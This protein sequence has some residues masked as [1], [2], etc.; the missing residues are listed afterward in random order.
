MMLSVLL[1]NI[2]QDYR[3]PEPSFLSIQ[4]SWAFETWTSSLGSR[5]LSG[6]YDRS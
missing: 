1:H 3:L 2:K 6:G 4:V 5:S